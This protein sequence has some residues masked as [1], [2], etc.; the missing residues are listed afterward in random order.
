MN[1]K[2]CTWRI[3]CFLSVQFFVSNSLQAQKG[4]D[5]LSL[6]KQFNSQKKFRKACKILAP[7]YNSHPGN[8]NTQWIY[9]QSLYWAKKF[10]KSEKVYEYAIAWHPENYYLRLDYAEKLVD[11]GEFE[12]AIPI[13][14]LYGAYD[15]TALDLRLTLAKIAFWK[16]DYKT[17]EAEVQKILKKQ[18]GQTASLKDFQNEILAAESP[19]IKPGFEY[20]ADT[21]PLQSYTPEVKTGFFLSPLAALQFNLSAPFY[22]G[23]NTLY[24]AQWLQAENKSFFYKMKLTLI[25]NIGAIKLPGN[26][27]SVTGKIDASKI[28]FKHLEL[29]AKIEHTPYLYALADMTVPVMQ[30]TYQGNIA[31]KNTNGWQAQAS[32]TYND[33]YA[34]NN[35]IYSIGAFGLT[36]PLKIEKFELRAGYAYNYSTSKYS[37]FVFV[38][39]E[40]VQQVIANWTPALTINGTGIYNPYFTPNAQSTHSV[41]FSAILHVSQKIELGAKG[42]IGVYCNTLNPY[43]YNYLEKNESDQIYI[44]SGEGFSEE[45]YYPAEIN[46]FANLRLS[47]RVSIGAEYTYLKNNFYSSNY[48]GLTSQISFW[49]EK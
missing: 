3:I 19:W 35:Y 45:R 16:C 24:N 12:K 13:L 26:T 46:I 30:L 43:F 15:S 20:H 23:N 38:P 34:T 25:T 40:T 27:T 5:T 32:A 44:A 22:E 21:Q 8:L 47:P 18:P 49:H 17:A 33:F 48:A 28:L 9:A 31:W 1:A 11:I 14:K 37:C 2:Y 29:D 6:A 39:G 7:Y 42:S 10:R 36:P 41:V 4:M